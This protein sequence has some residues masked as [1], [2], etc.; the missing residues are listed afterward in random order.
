[1]LTKLH[2]NCLENFTKSLIS[3][4]LSLCKVLM[5][6]G[7]DWSSRTS[8]FIDSVFLFM[9]KGGD[10]V[11]LPEATPLLCNYSKIFLGPFLQSTAARTDTS[12]SRNR[13]THVQWSLWDFTTT[14]E[15]CNNQVSTFT[16]VRA[17]PPPPS[18]RRQLPFDEGVP[19]RHRNQKQPRRI[20]RE[21]PTYLHSRFIPLLGT[22]GS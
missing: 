20:S 5:S 13:L 16:C 10:F 12:A 22:H 8:L 7:K 21:N 14:E 17:M 19:P 2:C 6:N 4:V 11:A 1:M 18:R 3:S 15:F 9:M